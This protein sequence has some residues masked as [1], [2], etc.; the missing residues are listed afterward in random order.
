M[1]V[2]MEVA[3]AVLILCVKTQ[4]VALSVTASVVILKT[5]F[6]ASVRYIQILLCF[7]FNLSIFK[8]K[9]CFIKE[10]N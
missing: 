4:L 8:T 7:V 1:S 2:L 10:S 9:Y 3:I 5:E 6:N